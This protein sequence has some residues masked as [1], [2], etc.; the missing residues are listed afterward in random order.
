M[1]SHAQ[2]LRTLKGAVVG[3]ALLLSACYRVDNAPGT[4]SVYVDPG[5]PGPAAGIGI[6]SQD[7]VSMTDQMMRDMLTEPRLAA[8]QRPPNVVI[9]SQY[10]DNESSTRFNKNA[11]TD[12]L[13]VS[14]NRAAKGRMVFLGRQYSHMVEKERDIKRDG[15]VDKGTT[16]TT[17]G[18]KGADYR[19]GG[20]ITSVDSRDPKAGIMSRYSQIVFEMVDQETG[21]IVWSGIYEITK[22]MQ[23]DV[24][25]R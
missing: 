13:R 2:R 22:A 6:E 15:V 25:Y 9:D 18:Q 19:L 1:F 21:E 23:D 11:I 10:F 4:P 7:I 12:R 5:S 14:L 24:V 8:Q 17:Q 16:G 3:T 20:R